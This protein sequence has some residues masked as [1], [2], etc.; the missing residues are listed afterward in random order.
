MKKRRLRNVDREEALRAIE[1]VIDL[2][3]VT[4]RNLR[5]P[6]PLDLLTA[7]RRANSL[8]RLLKES[9]A[10]TTLHPKRVVSA[11]I[12]LGKVAKQVYELLHCFLFQE[13]R[14]CTLV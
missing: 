3:K 14:A 12:Y 11:L 9:S 1:H 6:P 13:L 5:G 7:I 8:R 2:L 10:G 4:K